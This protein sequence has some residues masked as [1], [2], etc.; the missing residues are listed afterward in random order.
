M[1]VRLGWG[2]PINDRRTVSSNKVDVEV[3]ITSELLNSERLSPPAPFNRRRGSTF[4]VGSPS[5]PSFEDRLFADEFS[6]KSRSSTK[7]K[8][9]SPP[10]FEVIFPNP[11]VK[12]AEP[13]DA[14]PPKEPI[15]K[16]QKQM[17]KAERRELQEKQRAEKAARTAAGLPP[18]ENPKVKT[19]SVS[20]S[21]AG[22]QV[23]LLTP[24][25]QQISN[26]KKKLRNVEAK[27]VDKQCIL[28]SHLPPFEKDYRLFTEA[29]NQGNV[30][31]AVLNLGRHIVERTLMGGNARCLAMMHTFK[32]VIS[33]YATP[34]GV[35]LQ[36][37]LTQ[38][39]SR[40]VDFLTKTRS[41]AASMKTA[42]RFLKTQISQFPI[43]IPDAD[44]KTQLC[45][46]I[47]DFVRERITFANK[48]IQNLVL[49]SGKIK[50]GDVIMV[51]G[52][53]IL[54]I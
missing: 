33:D 42:I 44:A 2:R 26:A 18:K 12:S 39:I 36:R 54:F 51:Y 14:E 24:Q 35:T 30:H 22:S 47:D 4:M 28:L 7:E 31:P 38:H 50:H 45:D 8:E 32:K 49:G 16:S 23:D 29:Q 34:S 20:S 37:D 40:Q 43:D 19:T 11:V 10:T 41:L 6:V 21:R 1:I 15:K 27:Q 13:V 9:K 48:A 3:A 46:I 25:R 5:R 17:T 53:C 52:R